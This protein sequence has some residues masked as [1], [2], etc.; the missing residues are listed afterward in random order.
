MWRELLTDDAMINDIRLIS[1]SFWLE[2]KRKLRAAHGSGI[3]AVQGNVLSHV[4]TKI[5][6]ILVAELRGSFLYAPYVS[7]A[8]KPGDP[9]QHISPLPLWGVLPSAKRPEGRALHAVGQATFGK[10]V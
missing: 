3:T 2:E 5:C 8:T 1:L 10:A 4:A 7:L 9:R 6:F